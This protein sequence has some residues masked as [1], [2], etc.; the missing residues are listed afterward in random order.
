VV[1]AAVQL[2][3]ALSHCVWLAEIE[4]RATRCRDFASRDQCGIDRRVMAPEA[5]SAPMA[6]A[7]TCS[8]M[9]AQTS[10]APVQQ[11]HLP[12]DGH[13][14]QSMWDSTIV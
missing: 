1:V 7:S 10:H 13:C 2:A 6:Q 11:Q 9:I 14:A 12:W 5:N 8:W 3:N 4:W